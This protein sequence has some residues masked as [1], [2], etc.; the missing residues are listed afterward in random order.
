[1][2]QLNL[3]QVTSVA[4]NFINAQSTLTR[5][6]ESANLFQIG[7]Q[8]DQYL[9]LKKTL[10]GPNPKILVVTNP[11]NY[12][13]FSSQINEVHAERISDSFLKETEIEL[14]L[15]DSRLQ[16]SIIILTNNN[17]SNIGLKKFSDI[18]S[19]LTNSFFSIHDFDNHHWHE[20]SFFLATYSD[21]YFPAHQSSFSIQGRVNSNIIGNIPCGTIQWDKNFLINNFNR[22]TNSQR[23]ISPLGMHFYYP[24]FSYRNSVVNTL[25]NHSKY[26]GL[27]QLIENNFHSLSQEERFKEWVSHTFHWIVP[28]QNDLP[29]RFFDALITGGTPLVPNS[30]LPYLDNLGIPRHFYHSYSFVDIINPAQLFSNIQEMNTRPLGAEKFEFTLKSFHVDSIIS[31]IVK[32]S[33][34]VIN[35]SN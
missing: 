16:N 28:V 34:G 27:R 11:T 30:L 6:F 32:S 31:K 10:I 24:K 26:T 15:S 18:Y 13:H 14:L 21:A 35:N 33:L 9:K 2:F 19:R 1:M 12:F 22:I 8:K 29:I 3:D 23:I 20:L 5:E 4:S 25:S 17:V 7:F